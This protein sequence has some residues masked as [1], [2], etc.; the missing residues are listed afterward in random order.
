[1]GQQLQRVPCRNKQFNRRLY[2]QL[3]EEG[4]GSSPATMHQ[5]KGW[6]AFRGEEVTHNTGEGTGGNSRYV[7]VAVLCHLLQFSYLSRQASLRQDEL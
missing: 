6:L 4:G 3:A 7:H 5:M 2:K 1:M